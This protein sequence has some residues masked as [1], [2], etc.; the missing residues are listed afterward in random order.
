MQT[1]ELAAD[2][3]DLPELPTQNFQNCQN[4]WTC[5]I[6]QHS[7]CSQR[8]AAVSAEAEEEQAGSGE[9]ARRDIFTFYQCCVGSGLP[10]FLG[11]FLRVSRPE[12]VLSASFT[13]SRGSTAERSRRRT[14]SE[15]ILARGKA[16]PYKRFT[17]A[18]YVCKCNTLVHLCERES[19][20]H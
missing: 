4:Q 17:L 1:V 13:R 5:Q 18:P 8:A 10:G 2:S 20:Q 3:Q 19:L 16:F 14:G 12:K 11:N 9:K 7:S 6:H 15:S